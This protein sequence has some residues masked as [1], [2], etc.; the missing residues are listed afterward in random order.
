MDVEKLTTEVAVAD[1]D[2][3]LND[4]QFQ[5]YVRTRAA[6]FMSASGMFSVGAEKT[7]LWNLYA[8]TS[9]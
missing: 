9:S 4:L 3:A 1:S 5:R 8:D 2:E 6:S 7:S